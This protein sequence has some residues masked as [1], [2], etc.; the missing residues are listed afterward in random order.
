MLTS[1]VCPYT[2]NLTGSCFIGRVSHD[3]YY[4]NYPCKLRDKLLYVQ[5]EYLIRILG[6]GHKFHCFR[7]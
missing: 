3:N 4:S 7:R 5:I 1:S 6:E 2:V